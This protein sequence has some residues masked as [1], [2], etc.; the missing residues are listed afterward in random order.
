MGDLGEKTK[1]LVADTWQSIN[2]ELGRELREAGF[3]V[4]VAANYEKFKAVKD[5]QDIVVLDISLFRGA[6]FDVEEAIR[7]IGKPT[8]LTSAN[9]FVYDY[10]PENL[11]Q[12]GALY[13][14]ITKPYM[15]AKIVRWCK[16][17]EEG[18]K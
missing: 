10:F 16:R 2:I 13:D 5:E 15:N 6:S 4:A 9:Q 11:V 14:Y 12:E 7:S 3:E 8:I 17:I 1:V 18:L